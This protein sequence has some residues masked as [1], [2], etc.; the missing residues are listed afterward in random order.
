MVPT[1]LHMYKALKGGE[2]T[3]DST[4][5]R[6]NAVAEYARRPILF[7]PNAVRCGQLLSLQQLATIV[8]A[9]TGLSPH[10]HNLL[11]TTLSMNIAAYRCTLLTR[12]LYDDLWAVGTD[13]TIV[14]RLEW[15][16]V[17][18]TL[19]KNGALCPV[20]TTNGLIDH[21]ESGHCNPHAVNMGVRW[22]VA[23]ELSPFWDM[24]IMLSAQHRVSDDIWEMQVDTM[25][26]TLS[27]VCTACSGCAR[28]CICGIFDTVE[29]GRFIRRHG[30]TYYIYPTCE[31]EFVNF[32]MEIGNLP[33]FTDYHGTQFK[34]LYLCDL[35]DAGVVVCKDSCHW[36][37][38][39]DTP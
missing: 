28:Q 4:A 21:S 13:I 24:H 17:A 35:L 36:G 1:A 25:R 23:P 9:I 32:Y 15:K 29:P 10:H 38:R 11:P 19:A 12:Q 37:P 5:I 18:D 26:C 30:D 20:S 34:D 14:G 3:V 7:T 31:S 22:T 6:D 39:I 16:I 2:S 33:L 8:L 27:N